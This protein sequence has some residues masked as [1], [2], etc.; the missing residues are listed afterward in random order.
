MKTNIESFC[1][2]CTKNIYLELDLLLYS[3]KLF[4]PEVPI[5]VNCDNFIFDY[6]EIHNYGLK[7]Y[8]FKGLEKHSDFS[9]ID[10]MKTKKTEQITDFFIQ[11]T[12][13]MDYALNLFNNTMYLDCD[14]LLLSSIGDMDLTKDLGLCPH[15]ISK[16]D[17]QQYGTYNNGNLFI[18]NKTFPEWYRASVNDTEKTQFYDQYILNECHKFYSVNILPINYNFGWWRI[19]QVSSDE[20]KKRVNNFHLNNLLHYNNSPMKTIHTH[21]I[22]KDNPGNS[23]QFIYQFN[24]IILQILSKSD[25]IYNKLLINKIDKNQKKNL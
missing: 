13:A 8:K 17:E 10:Y 4:N 14:I 18:N 5:I 24:N 1:C 9:R 20:S 19:L 2:M 3:I 12:Y 7:I 22:Y 21:F 25:Y 11:S 23:N 16:E 15:Y 6:L